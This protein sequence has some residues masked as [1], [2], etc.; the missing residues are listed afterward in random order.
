M[1][2][3]VTVGCGGGNN[4]FVSPPKLL[5]TEKGKRGVGVISLF[6]NSFRFSLIISHRI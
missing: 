6:Y 1:L 4:K 5:K 3:K 2:E